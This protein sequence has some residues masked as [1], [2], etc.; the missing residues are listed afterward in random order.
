MDEED[1]AFKNEVA[2]EYV[3]SRTTSY[4]ASEYVFQHIFF[5]GNIFLYIFT[6]SIFAVNGSRITI[7][8]REV[9]RLTAW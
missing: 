6:M 8:V 4:D 2:S 1:V 3:L 5:I 9:F 7:I